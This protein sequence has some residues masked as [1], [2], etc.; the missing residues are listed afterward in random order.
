MSRKGLERWRR[1]QPRGSHGWCRGACHRRVRLRSQWRFVLLGLLGVLVLGSGACRRAEPLAEPLGT[2]GD[3]ALTSQRGEPFGSADLRGKVWVGSFM[4]TRCPTVCPRMMTFMVALQ[5]LARRQGVP[6]ELVTFS[7]DPEN[8]SP[9]VLRAFASKHGADLASWTFLT[10][11][12]ETVKRTSIEG[13]KLALEGRAD[14]EKPDFGILHGSQ[15]VLVDPK[16]QIRGYYSIS[17][18]AGRDKLLGAARTLLP[19]S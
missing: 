10:G 3:F 2:L 9:E 11:D 16:M 4:F 13:F 6:V 7:V 15:L 17:D 18:E 12:Y 19:G 8:D 5:E 1:A 14:S